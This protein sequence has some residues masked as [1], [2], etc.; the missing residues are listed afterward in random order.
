VAT[1][2]T[3][4]LKVVT[5]ASG[6]TST[7]D[8]DNISVRLAIPDRSVN[9][10]ALGIHGTLDVDAVATGAELKALSGFSASNYL[11]QPYNADLDFAD[12]DW[13]FKCWFKTSATTAHERLMMFAYYGG[14]WNGS[15]I[16]LR[17][18]VTTSYLAALVTDDS[19]ATYD[20]P[21]GT[22]AVDDDVWHLVHFTRNGNSFY[23]YL[24][25]ELEA[26][27]SVSAAA[28]SLSNSNATLMVGSGQND[29]L[30]ASNTS[31]QTAKVTLTATSAAEA[32]R[33]YESEKPMF[34]E[35]ADCVL[36]GSSDAVTALAYDDS[37]ELLHVGT[38][39]G[40][41]DFQGLVRVDETTNNTTEISA[42]GG[43]IVEEYS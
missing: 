20:T 22:R 1:G 43:L 36:N 26:S 27:A 25:G 9:N 13:T 17:I 24:D 11:K 40:R 28:G 2:T 39:G 5:S 32:K 16:Q 23:I 35:N 12:G 38:S 3:T 19:Y 29:S 21:T 6:H 10:N 7:S 15:A 31:I 8:I 41:S 4:Y 33:Q 34:N 18:N 14:A 30:P 37:T 42:Q